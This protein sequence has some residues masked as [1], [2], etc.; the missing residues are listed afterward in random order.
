MTAGTCL[1][2]HLTTIWLRPA[3][4]PVASSEM[5]G[6]VERLAGPPRTPA[7][8]ALTDLASSVRA[9][10]HATEYDELVD[11]SAMLP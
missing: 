9:A 1:Q 10:Q 11:I 2:T 4:G 3:D 8:V 6:E 5:D 7:S